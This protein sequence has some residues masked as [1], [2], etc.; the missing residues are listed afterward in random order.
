MNKPWIINSHRHAEAMLFNLTI[1]SMVSAVV[2][3]LFACCSSGNAEKTFVMML[4]AFFAIGHSTAMLMYTY[5]WLY[6]RRSHNRKYGS[7][8][9]N[10]CK[11]DAKRSTMTIVAVIVSHLTLMHQ[12]STHGNMHMP[13]T[14]FVLMLLTGMIVVVAIN[15]YEAF[16]LSDESRQS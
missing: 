7:F 1:M 13:K 3:A 5:R 8:V 11:R 15:V 9:P 4:C 10:G 6:V 2:T 16:Y 12:T 14:A